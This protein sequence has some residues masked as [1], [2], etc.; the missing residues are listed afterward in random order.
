MSMRSKDGRYQQQNNQQMQIDALKQQLRSKDE[1]LQ[2][3]VDQ[4]P[5]PIM[6]AM[7]QNP[8]SYANVVPETSCEGY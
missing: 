1:Q 6:M 8:N 3:L 5:Q 4:Q 2:Q 7:Y